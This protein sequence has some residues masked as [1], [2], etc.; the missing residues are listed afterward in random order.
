MT[1][2]ATG[3]SG[4]DGDAAAPL[5]FGLE[6]VEGTSIVGHPAV[7]DQEPYRFDGDEVQIST[8]WVVYRVTAE[9]P[10]EVFLAWVEQLDELAIAE[11]SVQAGNT[12]SEAWLRAESV[13][14][15]NPG[16]VPPDVAFL[17]LYATEDD[18]L[19]VVEIDRTEGAAD[20]GELR[21]TGDRGRLPAPP[22]LRG[23][24]ERSAGELL[25]EEKGDELEL[26][27][28]TSTDIP[29]L[30]NTFGSAGAFAVLHADDGDAAVAALLTQCEAFGDDAEIIGPEEEGD[31][32][33]EVITASCAVNGW[34]FDVVAVPGDGDDESTVYVRSYAL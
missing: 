30:P 24:A 19:L 29:T 26:P 33:A 20:P 11:M 17:R 18:P 8:L 25:L 22:T 2:G 12:A 21:I 27:E 15:L 28:G 6:H 10:G 34:A 5:P 9:N 14:P 4:D 32:E 16:D 13:N 31:D 23:D 7:F 1:I 3:C